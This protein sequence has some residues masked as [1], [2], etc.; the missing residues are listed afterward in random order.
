MERTGSMHPSL[1]GETENQSGGYGE[2]G[3]ASCGTNA[4]PRKG[5]GRS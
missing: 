5:A 4:H 1:R 2:R 3:A